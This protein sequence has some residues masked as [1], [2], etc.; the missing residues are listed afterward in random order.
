ME[1]TK[2]QLIEMLKVYIKPGETVVIEKDVSKSL[3]AKELLEIF[4]SNYFHDL[5]IEAVIKAYREREV[6]RMYEL[7]VVDPVSL[8][9]VAEFLGV[10]LDDIRY[11]PNE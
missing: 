11:K 5:G 9:A 7:D 4:R 10:N 3:T 6:L 2:E 8:K 1:Y